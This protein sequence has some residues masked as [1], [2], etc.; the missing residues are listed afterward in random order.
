MNVTKCF[1]KNLVL[2]VLFLAFCLSSFAQSNIEVREK[3]NLANKEFIKIFS[4]SG[5]GVAALYAKDA[6]VMPPN[7]DFIKSEGIANFW[8]GAFNAGIKKVNLETVDVEASDKIAT[9]T[10][11]FTLYDANDKVIDSGKY[12]VLWK[13]EDGKW[14]LF[15]DIW[16]SSS[17]GK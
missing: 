11:K 8:N 12:L 6:M 1:S 2:L 3:I 7:S 17:P 9:E 14:K 16:N 13:N 10:G 4:E 5:G 15:R